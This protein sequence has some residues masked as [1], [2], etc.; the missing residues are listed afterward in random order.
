MPS[1]SKPLFAHQN[2]LSDEA[3]GVPIEVVESTKTSSKR[4][5]SLH[6][7][8]HCGNFAEVFERHGVSEPVAI[9]GFDDRFHRERA[10]D[11][12]T[13]SIL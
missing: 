1:D 12:R 6:L 13:D 5:P 7:D 10:F 8:G 4:E 3:I 11:A 9:G 2:F